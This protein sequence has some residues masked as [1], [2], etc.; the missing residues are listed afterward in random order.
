MRAARAF[1]SFLGA[2][3]SSKTNKTENGAKSGGVEEIERP[4]PRKYPHIWEVSRV[5]NITFPQ[6][7]LWFGGGCKSPN[8]YSRGSK[9]LGV[10]GV[11]NLQVATNQDL[12]LGPGKA[13]SPPSNLAKGDPVCSPTGPTQLTRVR[14]VPDRCQNMQVASC[15][16][17]ACFTRR[18][19]SFLEYPKSNVDLSPIYVHMCNIYIYICIYVFVY[20]YIY[21]VDT[22][23]DIIYDNIY[24][25]M[26]MSVDANMDMDAELERGPSRFPHGESLR[27]AEVDLFPCAILREMRRCP[28]KKLGKPRWKSSRTTCFTIQKSSGTEI[29]YLQKP[30][31]SR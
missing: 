31:A 19:M 5:T 10:W 25:Y 24:I 12:F 7:A 2:C 20:I 8:N 1:E 17:R 29:Q 26:Y 21:D 3:G 30:P 27:L 28:P 6:I 13:N 14:S 9:R 18:T 11:L 4:P 22:N 23:I 15:Q 16:A